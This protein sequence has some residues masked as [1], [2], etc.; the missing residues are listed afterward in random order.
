MKNQAIS[1]KS[2]L[3]L[4]FA[5]ALV[6]GLRAPC[7]SSELA[8]SGPSHPCCEAASDDA[9]SMGSCCDE[10]ALT[11]TTNSLAVSPVLV[12]ELVALPIDEPTAPVEELFFTETR[13]PPKEAPST[14]PLTARAPPLR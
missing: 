8:N 10:A 9:P 1:C 2:A 5:F 14:K 13:P 3:A 4:L 6:V 12:C 11:N 7:Y